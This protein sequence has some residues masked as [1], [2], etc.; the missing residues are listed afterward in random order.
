MIPT[1][2]HL[3]S[4]PA[5][6]AY[7]NTAYNA[8]QLIASR[9]H[10]IAGVRT[11]DR[12]WQRSASSFFNDA[13]AVRELAATLFGGEA[14]GYAIVPAAS[15]G[16][17][18]AARAIEPHLGKGDRIVVMAR[19]FPSNVLPWKTVSRETGATLTTVEESGEGQWTDAIV[20]TIDRRTRVV[21]V[22]PCHWTNGTWIDLDAVKQ[23]CREVGSALVVDASQ[24]LG[25]LPLSMSALDP[26][27]LVAAGY[28]WL[29]CPYGFGLFYVSQRWRS[30]RPLEESWLARTG[31]ADF[32]KLVDYS[33]A[34][35]QGSRRFDVGEKCTPTILPGVIKAFQQLR[36]WG[37]DSIAQT[38]GHMTS[39]IAAGLDEL[40]FEVPPANVHCPHIIGARIPPRV[41]ARV[42]AELAD[43][44]I[45]ISQRGD[46][47]RFSPH[48]HVDE[49]DIH[50]LLDA[51]ADVA[52]RARRESE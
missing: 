3:F 22:S 25:A 48:L 12:P 7:F 5:E 44:D 11:K 17:S 21:A 37:V 39:R 38:L 6:V 14:E 42:V 27:F 32:A 13:E 31:A 45:Y 20:R 35:Q 15:Y 19:E 36:D 1:Q 41:R 24:A 51:L 52:S 47:L 26:D 28:K 16:I 34:Y 30:A 9:E 50:R 10:L 18:T 46:S 33:E 23:R 4:V 2:R 43:R 40:G 49:H 8:P 29:L